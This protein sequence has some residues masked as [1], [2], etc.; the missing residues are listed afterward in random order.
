[1]SEQQKMPDKDKQ[2]AQAEER[3][4]KWEGLYTE[5]LVRRAIMDAA[6]RAGAYHG[7]QLLPFLQEHGRLEEVK[8][9][10]VVYFVGED[11]SGKKIR[12]TP[13][14]AV[15]HLKK[16][17]DYW[18]LF[19]DTMAAQPTLAAP[20]TPPKIDFKKMTPQQ[21]LEIREKNPELLGLKPKRP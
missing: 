1:M 14:Q 21:Y 6:D 17:G 9:Q 20:S 13:D 15:E 11:D 3:A 12:R 8:G 10:Y 2:L 19:K 5:T 16:N 4:K 18:N 7:Q